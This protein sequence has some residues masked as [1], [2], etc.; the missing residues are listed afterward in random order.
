VIVLG[1]DYGQ[2]RV[3]VALCDTASGLPR[4]LAT[5]VRHGRERTLAQIADLARR[6]GATQ[7][8]VGVPLAPDGGVGMRGQQARNFA[9][10][11]ERASGLPVALQ[12][13]RDSS[14]EAMERLIEAGV[15]Q[16]K[17]AELVDQTAAMLVLERWLSRESGS[18]RG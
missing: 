10:D 4:G 15:G 16:R 2:A 12:D 11:L 18:A 8:V 9:R 7:V 14:R 6:H 1:V 13:E 3:G 17:R 5:L